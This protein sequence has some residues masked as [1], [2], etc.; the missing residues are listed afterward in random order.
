M[1]SMGLVFYLLLACAVYTFRG[2]TDIDGAQFV[3]PCVYA[4][5]LG[6][7]FELG[8]KFERYQAAHGHVAWALWALMPSLGVVGF[9]WI[10]CAHYPM[11]T[12]WTMF[13]IAAVTVIAHSAVVARTWTQHMTSVDVDPKVRGVV[14]MLPGIAGL[15]T[16]LVL[17][18]AG[19]LAIFQRSWHS[20]I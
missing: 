5:F 11:W 12:R 16:Y 7:G 18:V 10:A 2:W 4:F 20:S 6:T 3:T 17:G 14:E 9:A 1:I 13:A 15:L 8:R 19:F